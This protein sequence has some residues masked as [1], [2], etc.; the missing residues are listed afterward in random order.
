MKYRD[1]MAFRQ[2][3]QQRLKDRA[4]GDGTLLVRN[5][6]RVAF[7]RLLARLLA[8]AQEQWVLKGG[9][10]LDLRL[11]T[12]ARSTK[13]V[14]IEW[15]AEVTELL[16]VLLDAANYDAGD[17]FEFA[18]ER[19]GVP[20]DRLGGSHR[21]RVSASLAGR[22]FESFLLDVG[23]RLDDALEA[24]TLRTDDFLGFA[25]IEPVEVQ[26]V[27]LELQ[28]AEKLHAYTRVY[29]GGRI[30]SRTKDLIDL[31]LIAELS[32]LDAAGLRREIDTIFELRATHAAPASLPLP[33]A[34]WAGPFRELAEEVGVPAD[35]EAGHRD[36][37]AL[38]DPILSGE[39][40]SGTWDST[41]RRWVAEKSSEE[42]ST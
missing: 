24:E 17:F 39:V 14:D 29:E 34:E 10:A 35:L 37:A 27:P 32:Q 2:A 25:E 23:F 11:A 12:R 16:D 38:V 19:A 15:R 8:V 22:S 6:K 40:A 13:D 4:D 1:E 26:A 9:F 20:E 33:P 5:R 31:A 28:V 3:L 36:A 7:D 21:F 42:R 18:I 41:Q 30:S